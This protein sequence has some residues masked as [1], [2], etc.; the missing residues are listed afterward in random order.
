MRYHFIP[1]R[2]ADL[3]K[4]ITSVGKDEGAIR[5]LTYSWW[6]CKMVWLLWKIVWQFLKRLKIELL[7]DSAIPRPGGYPRELKMYVHTKTC[8]GR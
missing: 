6:G 3:R 1:T 5:T 8:T 7:Y 4:T 2:T